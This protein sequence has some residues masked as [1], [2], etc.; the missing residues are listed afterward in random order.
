MNLYKKIELLLNKYPTKIKVYISSIV[1]LSLM[2][3]LQDV[4]TSTM[5]NIFIIAILSPIIIYYCT[6]L[7][8]GK[9]NKYND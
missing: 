6:V 7:I 1:L 3:L 9:E 8:F 4:L 2:I 5:T